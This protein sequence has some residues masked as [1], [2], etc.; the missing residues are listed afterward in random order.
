MINYAHLMANRM[1]LELTDVTFSGASIGD[2]LRERDCPR[3]PQLAS[4]TDRTSLVTITCG[5]NDVGYG[6]G[7]TLPSLPRPL[8]WVLGARGRLKDFT[9]PKSLDDR[10][11]RLDEDLVSLITEVRD[12]APHAR[13]VIVGYLTILPPDSVPTDPLPAAVAAWGR[14][15]A[16][17][18]SSTMRAAAARGGADF[19]DVAQNSLEHHAWSADPWTN[20][21][22]YTFRGG[23]SYHPTASG[24]RAVAGMLEKHL[25]ARGWPATGVDPRDA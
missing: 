23:A 13:I 5:G 11:R 1:F 25:E 16:Q 24:M 7:L 9:D 19:L 2:I 8:G 21:F 18:L 15:V 14:E 4:V 10:F 20:S 12:R 3:D 6:L 17:R 22:H